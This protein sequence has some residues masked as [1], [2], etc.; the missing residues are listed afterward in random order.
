MGYRVI[1]CGSRHWRDRDRIANRLFDL[2]TDS[3]VV[4]GGSGNADNMAEQE[5][6]KLG[7]LTEVHRYQP[8]I[9]DTVSG[10]RAPL[11]RN[12]HMADLGADLCIAFWDGRST[13]TV[14]MM[15]KAKKQGI[16]VEII[17]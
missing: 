7:L 1:V 15:D 12:Q 6:Q 8:F 11:V 13:G 4:T 14:D 3:T 16:P 5:A 9:S 2:P 10:K 17:T